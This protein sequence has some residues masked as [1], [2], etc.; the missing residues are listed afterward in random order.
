MQAFLF[1]GYVVIGF[2][3]IFAI[4]EGL[5]V[6]LGVGGFISAMIAM[7]ATYI[8]VLGQ[9]LG[10]YGAVNAWDWSILQACLLFFWF[11]PFMLV[12]M[13]W[14]LVTKR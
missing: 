2:V 11:V 8:P 6:A 10:V 7:F 3:Q 1:I 9:V 14:D 4:M 13:G 5:Q 12:G